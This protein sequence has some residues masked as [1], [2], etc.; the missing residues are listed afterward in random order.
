MRPRIARSSSARKASAVRR[1]TDRFGMEPLD[2]RRMFSVLTLNGTSGP[3]LITVDSSGANLI[4]VINGAFTQVPLAG[5]DSIV[6]NG[7]GGDDTLQV[8]R[9]GGLPTTVNGGDNNDTINIS[10]VAKNLAN[11]VGSVSVFGG[12]GTDV[13]NYRDDSV[14]AAATYDVNNI[15]VKRGNDSAGSYGIDVEK[16]VVTTGNGIDTVNVPLTDVNTAV[17]LYSSGG[18]DVVGI[19]NAT[20]GLGSVR[21][22]VVVRNAP[23][24]S[25]LTLNDTASATGRN[26]T[27]STAVIDGSEFGTITGFNAAFPAAAVRYKISDVQQGVTYNGGSGVDGFDI[28]KTTARTLV[29][30]GGL[31]NDL[32]RVGGQSL[33]GSVNPIDAALT[34]DGGAGTDQLDFRDGGQ[35]LLNPFTVTP[36]KVSAALMADVNYGAMETVIV[37]TGTALGGATHTVQNTA[38]GTQLSF[39]DG[40]GNG[41]YLI[42]ETAAGSNVRISGTD[43]L[44]GVYVND[45]NV[46]SASVEFVGS[47]V[48]AVGTLYV[49]DGGR[50]FVG[51]ENGGGALAGTRVLRVRDFSMDSDN[52]VLDVRNN[53]FVYDWDTNPA[54]QLAFV[55]NYV[56]GGYNGGAWNGA[57]IRSSLGNATEYAVGYANS[58]DILGAGGGTIGGASVDG[59]ATIVRFT[60]YGDANLDRTVGLADFARLGSGFNQAG[61][62]WSAGNFNY[63]GGTTIA[64]FSLMA[65]NYNQ[66]L[67]GDVARPGGEPSSVFSATRI[68]DDAAGE[69][70]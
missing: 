53:T 13:V 63:A 55:G 38:A 8:E 41:N 45:D 48:S 5:I 33:N 20:N 24:F 23:S 34:L 32:F 30:N 69:I 52:G 7:L 4:H 68:V 60:R 27:F 42:K 1:A 70:A 11:V 62:H 47:G 35:A 54:G 19:G 18:N 15:D 25:A 58:G 39:V 14:A 21:S 28:L 29:I 66:A 26:V 22:E 10:P 43:L 37:Y 44:D 59:T 6:I 12:N 51:S 3:D 56:A 46:G 2:G 57:G 49:Y 65:S 40:T 31:G 64:D 17:E 9:N 61:T 50:A 16:I 67:A 36:T